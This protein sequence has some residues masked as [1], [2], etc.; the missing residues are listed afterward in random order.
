MRRNQTVLAVSCVVAALLGP[1]GAANAK[2][3]PERDSAL[4]IEEVPAPM[5]AS[6]QAGWWNPLDEFRGTT[7]FAFA[8][9]AGGAHVTS[10]ASR[11]RRG[12]WTVGCVQDTAGTCASAPNDFGHNQASVAVDGDG[13]IHVFADMHNGGW[14]YYRSERPGD[15]TSI[16]NRSS[17]MPDGGGSFTYPVT[18][19][20]QNGDAYVMVRAQDPSAR[21]KSGRLYRWDNRENAWSTV[22]VVAQQENYAVYPD[23]LQSDAKG[24]IHVL[25]EWGRYPSTAI[26]H[27]TSYL[28]YQPRTNTFVDAAGAPVTTPVTNDTGG[29]VVVQPLEGAED[30]QSALA[31]SLGVQTSK[32]SVSDRAPGLGSI[33]YRYRAS[34]GANWE[35]RRATWGGHEWVREVV[36]SGLSDTNA[37]VDV[38]EGRGTARVYYVKRGGCGGLPVVAERRDRDSQGTWT[39]TSFGPGK[40]IDRLAVQQRRDGTD[41]LYLSAPN[42]VSATEGKLYFGTLSRRGL[43]PGNDAEPAAVVKPATA[44]LARGATVE[45]SST[46]DAASGPERVTDGDLRVGQWVSQASDT[47]PTL[48]VAFA[49]E[50]DLQEVWLYSGFPGVYTSDTM[51]KSFTVQVPDGTGWRN[52]GEISGNA[53]NPVSLQLP[54]GTRSDRVRLVL[55]DPTDAR[56]GRAR[57]F[58]VEVYERA[59]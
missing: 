2:D 14:R 29:A 27:R 16:L 20:A 24:N 23:D 8:G 15:V 6:N 53:C 25:W 51:V 26:R 43:L 50:A 31:T 59:S 22:A 38:T 19:R 48:T 1:V 30:P 5:D 21:S 17:E 3:G 10:I 52:V 54:A 57:V 41:V 44:N 58:E 36:Y 47:A 28:V 12:T 55:T 32:L 39:E 34:E 42:A 56:D 40:G 35:V 13:Y 7:Y 11:D 33:V 46:L 9:S 45:A 4:H 37:A 18:T 49:R